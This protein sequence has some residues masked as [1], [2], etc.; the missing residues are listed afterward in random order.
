MGISHWLWQL[1]QLS[2][3]KAL[4]APTKARRS[5]QGK[6]F[7]AVCHDIDP[8]A[9]TLVAGFPPEA[10]LDEAR[11]RVP[12]DML[13]LGAALRGART[14]PARLHAARGPMHCAPGCP[15]SGAS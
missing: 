1:A 14:R 9:R 12:Y 10:G 4:E 8:E 7:E 2:R 15:G 6:Y 11:F 5:A 3:S 13:I